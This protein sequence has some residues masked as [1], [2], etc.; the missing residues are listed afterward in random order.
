MSEVLLS[1]QRIQMWVIV[2]M[3]ETFLYGWGSGEE[4]FVGSCKTWFLMK[5]EGRVIKIL[6]GYCH[7]LMSLGG[8]SPI[9]NWFWR[10]KV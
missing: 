5:S 10:A 9:Y 2:I 8:S 3:K 1:V 6:E 4:Y 7:I